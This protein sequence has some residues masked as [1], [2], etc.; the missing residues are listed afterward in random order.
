MSEIAIDVQPTPNPN[1]MKFTL[2]RPTTDGSP[3]SFR[4]V[5]EAG[6]DKLAAGLMA[7]EG[8][9]SIFMTANFISVNKTDEAQWDTIVPAATEAIQARFAG[10]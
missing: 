3:R 4:S 7:I 5:G 6:G 10:V 9:A 8:V 1:A 2:D